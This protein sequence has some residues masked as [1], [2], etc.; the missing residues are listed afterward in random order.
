MFSNTIDFFSTANGLETLYHNIDRDENTA[1]GFRAL[2][3]NT[4]GSYNTA[5]GVLRF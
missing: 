1:T 3:S 5:T 2:L 4:S